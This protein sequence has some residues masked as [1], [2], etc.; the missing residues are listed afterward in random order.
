MF[1]NIYM[2]DVNKVYYSTYSVVY[3]YK[4][5]YRIKWKNMSILSVLLESVYILP[6]FIIATR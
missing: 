1:F 4:V 6:I 2:N 3:M 5:L